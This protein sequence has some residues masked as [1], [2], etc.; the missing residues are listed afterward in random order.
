MSTPEAKRAIRYEVRR[1]RSAR[2][3]ADLEL[4]ADRF[5]VTLDHAFDELGGEVVAAFLPL[6][7][8]PPLGAFLHRL[9]TLGTRVIVPVSHGEGAMTW[10]DLNLESLAHP[11]T[12]AEGMPIPQGALDAGAGSA[13]V[14]DLVYIPAAAVDSRGNR[15]GWGKG[16][17][18]RYLATV[19]AGTPIVAVVFDDEVRP[20]IPVESHDIPATHV[21]TSERFIATGR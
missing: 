17:Y 11:A 12:D 15:L 4:L 19:P 2:S 18:D 6:P 13:S 14:P 21:V 3:A 7:T 20:D 5:L 8:E 1:S 9:L 10:H 16:Y